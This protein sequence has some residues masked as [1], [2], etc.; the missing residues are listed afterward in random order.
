MLQQSRA[1]PINASALSLGASYT[2]LTANPPKFAY[3]NNIT[4]TSTKFTGNPIISLSSAIFNIA[5]P[6]TTNQ[7]FTAN[8]PYIGVSASTTPNPLILG[9]LLLTFDSNSFQ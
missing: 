5:I 1:I 3:N 2:D 8:N 9:I 7:V 6:Y 4:V